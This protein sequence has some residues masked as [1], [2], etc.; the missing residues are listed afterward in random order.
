[1]QMVLSRPC[2]LFFLLKKRSPCSLEAEMHLS[3]TPSFSTSVSTGHNHEVSF[4]QGQLG[5]VFQ[6]VCLKQLM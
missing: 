3:E 1:M 6:G 5:V 4:G 2:T